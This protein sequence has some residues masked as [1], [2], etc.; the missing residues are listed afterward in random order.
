MARAVT[1]GFGAGL[2]SV[3]GLRPVPYSS[4]TYRPLVFSIF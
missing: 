1:T 2:G 3:V 4:A